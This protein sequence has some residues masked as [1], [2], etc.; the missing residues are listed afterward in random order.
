MVLCAVYGLLLFACQ[1]GGGSLRTESVDGFL[2]TIRS[3][4]RIGLRVVWPC[5]QSR[6]RQGFDGYLAAG[7]F[8]QSKSIL[9]RGPK[10]GTGTTPAVQAI[11]PKFFNEYSSKICLVFSCHAHG[12]LFVKEIL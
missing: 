6:S 5:F 8:R 2:C 11:A 9:A 10:T 3:L 12:R 4:A 7:W 1:Y